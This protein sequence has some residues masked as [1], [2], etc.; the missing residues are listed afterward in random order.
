MFPFRSLSC[1]GAPGHRPGTLHQAE[2]GGV[3]RSQ[4]GPLDSVSGASQEECV[5]ASRVVFLDS[6]TFRCPA[7][8]QKHLLPRWTRATHFKRSLQPGF[9]LQNCS[10]GRLLEEE[11]DLDLSVDFSQATVDR[12]LQKWWFRSDCIALYRDSPP[13]EL[14]SFF[15]TVIR[16]Q[17]THAVSYGSW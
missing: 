12:L 4:N 15:L 1:G 8:L 16:I 9:Q 10:F 6:R 5:W 7:G 13:V 17:G 2:R 3:K 11:G 14:L